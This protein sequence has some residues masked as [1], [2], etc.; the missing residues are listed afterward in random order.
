LKIAQ[1]RLVGRGH[2]EVAIQTIGRDQQIMLAVSGGHA[3][4]ALA[5]AVR[6]N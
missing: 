4:L 1:P 5:P 6:V 3:K 2:D